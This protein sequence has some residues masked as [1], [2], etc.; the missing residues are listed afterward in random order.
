MD[1]F[2]RAR[3]PRQK[4]LA[5]DRVIH[6]LHESLDQVWTTPASVN[7]IEGT[8]DEVIEFLDSLAYGDTADPAM[9]S[10]KEQWRAKMAD[11]ERATQE[12]Y[13]KKGKVF[14]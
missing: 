5:I 7:L 6:A 4:M 8:R 2:R 11:S 1:E 9:R 13:A 12:Y 14:D 10:R 3:G